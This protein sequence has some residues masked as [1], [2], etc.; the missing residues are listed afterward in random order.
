MTLEQ[1]QSAVYQ[2][3]LQAKAMGITMHSIS[4]HDALVNVPLSLNH[5]HHGTAF[6]GSLYSACTVACYA[7]LYKLQ[8]EAGLVHRPLV[9]GEGAIK[10][11]RPVDKDFQVRARVDP[12]S[13]VELLGK[14]DGGRPGKITLTAEVLIGKSAPLCHYSGEFALLRV[15]K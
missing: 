7:L 2:A 11:I 14:L 6:G 10:Y 1:I 12:T 8:M 3:I 9:I 5:N 13:W 15:T 4:G